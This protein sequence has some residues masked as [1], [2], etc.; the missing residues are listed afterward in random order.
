MTIESSTSLKTCEKCKIEKNRDEFHQ[1][2]RSSDKLTAYCCQCKSEYDMHRSRTKAGVNT[3]GS[4][5]VVQ[6]DMEGNYVN[7]YPSIVIAARAVG[8]APQTIRGVCS[9][10][11]KSS[12]GFG[13]M[14]GL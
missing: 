13:W 11:R 4:R 8:R 14:Y 3:N 12:A 5:K 2:S 7:A 6:I 10:R 9:K 1:N